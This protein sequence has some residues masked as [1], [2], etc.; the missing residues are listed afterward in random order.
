MMIDPITN[1]TLIGIVFFACGT[2]CIITAIIC[3]AIVSIAN[4]TYVPDDEADEAD[5]SVCA[6]C[7]HLEHWHNPAAC[8]Y[9]GCNCKCFKS[10]SD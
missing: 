4:N 2:A 7:S 1:H 5:E 10:E 9:V 6:E 3:G 8:H